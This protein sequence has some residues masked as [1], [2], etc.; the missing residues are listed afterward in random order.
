MSSPQRAPRV[1]RMCKSKKKACGKELPTCSYC[2]KRGFECIYETESD[3]PTPSDNGGDVFKP[4]SLT[5]FPMSISTTTLDRTMVCHMQYLY[6]VVGQSPLQAGKLF[7]ENFQRWLPILAPRRLQE[8]IELSERGLPGADAS[9]LLLAICLVTLRSS[10]DLADPF[11]HHSAVHVTV[12]TLYAQ[13]QAITHASMALV[14]AG[15]ILSAYE[16][17]SG[18]IDSAYIS[19]VACI[20]MAQVVGVDTV[21]NKMGAVQEEIRLQ[22]TAEWNLWWS[23]LVLERFILLEYSDAGRRAPVAVC[24]NSDVPLPSDT[25]SN[26][27]YIPTYCTMTSSTIQSSSGLS[28]FGR[29][30]QAIYMLDRCLNE[31]NQSEQVDPESKLLKLQQL[32]KELQ[33]RLSVFMAQTPHEPSLRCGT[34]ATVIRSLY[35]LHNEILSI[36]D[37]LPGGAHKEGWVKSSDAALETITTIM[38]DVANHHLDYIAR[39]GVD[40]LAFCCRDHVRSSTQPTLRLRTFNAFEQRKY[41]ALSYTWKPPPE[42]VDD[43][44][45][46]YLV[47]DIESGQ[48]EPS[49]VRNTVFS[50]I[51]R[52][53]DH[54][55]CRY[56]W[57]DQHCIQQKEGKEKE[58]GMQAMDRVYSLSDHPAALLSQHINTSSELKLLTLILSG[59]FV[60]R[61][62]DEYLPSSQ[63]HHKTILAAFQLL[64]RITSDTW[65]SR[66]WTYQENYRA[67]NNMTL[68]VT[69][70]PIPNLEKPSRHYGSLDGELLI[71]SKA[72]CEE[73][74]KLCQAYSTYEPAFPYLN[75]ILSRTKRYKISLVGRD[76]SAPVSMTPTIIEDVASRQLEREWDRLAIIANCCQYTKRLNSKQLRSSNHSLSL[77]LLTLVLV[78]GEILRNHPQDEFDVSAARK[79]TITEFLH[80]IFFYGLDCPWENAKLTF[81]KGCRF[82]NITLTEE[83]VRTMGYLWR[84]DGEIPTANFSN[85][86][87]TRKR[88]RN[89]RPVRRPLEW[90]AEQLY[91]GSRYL[92]QRIYEILD[93]EEPSS[94]ATDWMLNMVHKVEEAIMQGKLIHTAKLLGPDPPGVAVFVCQAEDTGTDSDSDDHDEGSYVFTSFDSEQY[95]NGSSFVTETAASTTSINATEIATTTTE[96]KSE[97]ESRT[98]IIVEITPTVSSVETTTTAAI[99]TAETTTAVTTT[100]SEG[101]E[102]LQSIYMYA[103]NGAEKLVG[104]ITSGDYSS[105]LAAETTFAENNG[106]S[107]LDCNIINGN[108]RQ[109]LQCQYGDQGVANFWTCAGH[110]TLVKPGFDFTSK[111]PRAAAAYKLGYIEVVNYS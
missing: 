22:A 7:L 82:A 17:A 74:T 83:G 90:L 16:Y 81:N 52:Y 27:E 19:I 35:I 41:V 71:S 23:I 87:Q 43:S 94:P 84:F 103:G 62:G 61:R 8:H 58:I 106:V 64:H 97:S 55:K 76:K 1:C 111:C 38:I 44:D 79:M 36:S 13:V 30:A 42:E 3:T 63:S 101:P 29:Q 109:T 105:A 26:G 88:K 98:T 32:D 70:S 47:Q 53:M 60:K 51:K 93:L 100:T 107:P 33:E 54:M 96:S 5:L 37:L 34:I 68:L 56:L 102:A 99:T 11:L 85:Y 25:E 12:K 110:L 14:Q 10:G 78:N 66:G 108:G 75:T 18:Q 40:S 31:I 20:R 95:D 28:S 59:S 24:P 91:D 21:Y 49:S 86:R 9:V 73:A 69:H 4:W 45:G 57:I 65:F 39:S 104:Y 2:F 72:F 67:N 15:V 89:R 6:K 46:G 92:S 48:P 50:R 80:K 77:S